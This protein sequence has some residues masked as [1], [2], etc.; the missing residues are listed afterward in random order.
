MTATSYRTAEEIGRTEQGARPV[1]ALGVQS[2]AVPPSIVDTVLPNG[3]RVVAVRKPSAPMVELRL[4]IPFAGTERLHAARA[5]V[6][7]NVLLTGTARRDRARMD[8]DLAVVGGDLNAVVDPERLSIGGSA[9][10]SGLDVLLD[11]VGDALTGAVYPDDEVERESARLV[12]R[13][14]MARSQPSVIAHEA[15]QSHR[16]GDHPFAKEMPEAAEIGE[17]DP[18]QVRELHRKAVVPRGSLLVLV[19]DVDPDAAVATVGSVLCGWQSDNSA[20]PLPTLPE[21]TPSDVLLV[22]RAGAVQSQLRLSAQTVPRTDPGYAAL[23]VA[24]LVYG[25][26]FSSR[27]VENIREDKG[28]T[29]GAHSYFEFTPDGATVLVEADT[30]SAVTPA[31][32]WETRYELGRLVLSPPT[33]SEVDSACQYAIGSLLTSTASQAGLSGTLAALAGVGLGFE[34]L[35]DHPQRLAS[36]TVD[37]VA[38]AAAK[39]FAPSRFTGVLVGDAEQLA[40]QL[41]AIGGV[42]LP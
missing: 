7:A 42:V 40:P 29:Y 30:A 2:E 3:L 38:E 17:V 28:F 41:R 19:G 26:Y 27:L 36:V 9:L 13:I 1:P 37:Q 14:T 31:A 33:E 15:L 5:E 12:E 35:R 39:F 16:Y 22:H 8:T 11:V 25:G 20:V 23:Q 21:L 6:L 32:L 4:R 34:W 24:N 10:A 18:E